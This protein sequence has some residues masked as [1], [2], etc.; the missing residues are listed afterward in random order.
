MLDIRDE[1][2]S[3]NQ[4]WKNSN[5]K[6]N[7]P[8]IFF[9]KKIYTHKMEKEKKEKENSILF[10]SKK[11][12][13]FVVEKNEE[14]NKKKLVENEDTNEGRWS[15]EEHEKFLDG[16]VQYGTNWR[17]VKS[18]IN[19]RTSIQVRS[20]AQKFFRKLKMCKDEQL[21]IDFTKD[22]IS[23]IRD[24]IREIKGINGNY[25]IKYIFKYLSDKFDKMKKT[26]KY[27]FQNFV[28]NTFENQE[29]FNKNNNL[30]ENCNINLNN[31]NN[32]LI[33]ENSEM[34]ILNNSPQLINLN[35]IYNNTFPLNN[36]ILFTNSNNFISNNFFDNQN[37]LTNFLLMNE[38]KQL[39]LNNNSNSNNSIRDGFI[40]NNILSNL[41]NPLFLSACDKLIT[42]LNIKNNNL[43]KDNSNNGLYTNIASN[44]GINNNENSQ[45]IN[46]NIFNLDHNNFLSNNNLN[47][48]DQNNNFLNEIQNNNILNPD[49]LINNNNIKNIKNENNN[50]SGQNYIPNNFDHRYDDNIFNFCKNWS[51]NNINN[52]INNN[53]INSDIKNV[54]NN[55]AKENNLNNK[56]SNN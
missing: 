30:L 52:H 39:Y 17:K 38:L 14:Y 50:L 19:S 42:L 55:Y 9:F 48:I 29:F 56:N 46:S 26:K 34:N 11:A 16:I 53:I 15:K 28:N 32:L 1:K 22:D 31:N 45:N 3:N 8:K 41:N 36:N 2:S 40:I 33:N 21:G 23:S 54:N 5:C 44:Y 13:R 6:I 18:L 12:L 10:L 43:K 35:Q 7:K 27:G 51:D 47:I 25:N 49:N 4:F 20:H 37:A 24:M